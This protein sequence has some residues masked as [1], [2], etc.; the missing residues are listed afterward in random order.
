MEIESPLILSLCVC[1]DFYISVW[2]DAQDKIV[3]VFLDLSKSPDPCIFNWEQ[4][5]LKLFIIIIICLF[6]FF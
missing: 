6:F 5:V 4:I 2:H 3:Q 1:G